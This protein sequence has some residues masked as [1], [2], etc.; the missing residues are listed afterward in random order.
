MMANSEK[1]FAQRR[2][3]FQTRLRKNAFAYGLIAFAAI[4]LKYRYGKASVED[5][6]WLVAPLAH[7][8]EL[9]AGIRFN[10]EPPAGFVSTSAQ[11]II[12]PACSGI[13]F[14]VVCF[15]ALSLSLVH[16]RKTH[17]AKV[18]WVALAL[19][20]AYAVTLCANTIRIIAAVYLYR[21]NIYGEWITPDRVHRLVGIAIYL[22]VLLLVYLATER[23]T[24]Q[25]ALP[26]G[27]RL[28]EM[29]AF[30]PPFAWYI[31]FTIMIPLLT[32]LDRQGD[33]L[34]IEHVLV[35]GIASAC[36]FVMCLGLVGIRSRRVDL[37]GRERE[38]GLRRPFTMLR[39]KTITAQETGKR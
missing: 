29:R 28:W 13:T 7:L 20:A 2:V 12:A 10:W 3:V 36:A 8:V 27:S 19:L 16:R 22:G 38:D 15:C 24:R 1:V 35:V 17:A 31:L 25:H 14:L 5:L 39:I 37:R 30:F 21:V 23:M 18:A 34:L 33:P 26:F 32:A 6:Y 9:F 11:V 4:G